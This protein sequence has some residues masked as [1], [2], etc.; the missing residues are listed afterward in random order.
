MTVEEVVAEHQGGGM[1]VQEVS[2]DQKRLGQAVGAGLDRVLDLHPP[3]A[4]I[5]QQALKGRLVVG[6]ADDQHLPNSRQHQ[7]AERAII[8]LS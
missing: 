2:A 6:S 4:A 3:A 5:S 7:R 8:G 1:A